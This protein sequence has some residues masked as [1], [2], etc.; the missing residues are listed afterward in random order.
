MLQPYNAPVPQYL[1]HN[2]VDNCFY[3]STSSDPFTSTNDIPKSAPGEPCNSGNGVESSRV[4]A[5][6]REANSPVSS[7]LHGRKAGFI[8][9]GEQF[10]PYSAYQHGSHLVQKNALLPFP[11]AGGHE[12]GVK[13]DPEDPTRLI[14][15]TYANEAFFYQNLGPK[16]DK[17][18]KNSWDGWRPHYYGWKELPGRK[19]NDGLIFR[20]TFE[21]TN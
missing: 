13:L 8:Q 12:S 17:T 2:S 14:K 19:V 21:K 10:T 4:Q 1:Q 16:L 18:L 5:H 6:S 11:K 7:T 20:V 9:E 15:D 3:T